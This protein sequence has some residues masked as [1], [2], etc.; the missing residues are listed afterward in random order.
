MLEKKFEQ[1]YLQF[2]ANYYRR[3]VQAIGVRDGSL[4]ATEAYC[5]EI[6]FLLERPTITRFARFL[7]VSIPNANYKINSL[8]KKGYVTKD[9]SSEDRRESRLEVT[10]KFLAYYGLNNDDNARLMQDIRASF[11]MRELE[12][13]EAIIDRVL[14]L[15]RKEVEV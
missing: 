7:G 2:R 6:I 9:P 5:V 14:A 8:V 15:M 11:D 1:L 3:M 10:N 12:E 13:L 4:T